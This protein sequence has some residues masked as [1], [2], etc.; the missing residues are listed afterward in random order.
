M[1][2]IALPPFLIRAGRTNI[3]ARRATQLYRSVG[4]E[5]G[6]MLETGLYLP[7]K[8]Y[9]EGLGFEVK[10]EV[11]GCD[12]VALKGDEPAAV[13]IGELKQRFNLDLVLQAMDRLPVCDEVWLAVRASKR[14]GGRERDPRVKRLCRMLGVGLLVVLGAGRVEMMIEPG[15]HRLRRD[16]KRRSKIVTEHQRRRGDPTGGGS[17]RKPVMTAY[18]QQALR[19]A[20]AL[21]AGPARPRD[22]KAVAPDAPKILLRN[23]YGWFERLDRGLYGLAAGGRTALNVWASDVQL[24]S[25]DGGQG[26]SSVLS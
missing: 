22:L 3:V 12:L 14:G 16:A 2:G 19:C 21:A 4:D 13:V 6:F 8:K 5:D 23:V 17:T 9:L 1:P 24:L 20:A 7:V 18:R 25:R 10:G 26:Q 11:C 15:P